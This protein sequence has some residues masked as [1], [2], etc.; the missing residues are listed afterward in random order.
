AATREQLLAASCAVGDRLAETALC[1]AG[2]VSWIGL[3]FVQEKKWMLQPLGMD[4]YD[5]LP[6]VGLFL[7]HLGAI[8]GEEKYTNLSRAA[9]KSLRQ[10][11]AIG[12]VNK[13]MRGIGAFSGLGGLIYT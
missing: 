3:R 10:W 5:G 6:G 2:D 9:L 12:K 8:S 11:L 4:L 13:R 1:G 7:A